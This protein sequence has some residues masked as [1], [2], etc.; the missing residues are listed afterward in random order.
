MSMLNINKEYLIFDSRDGPYDAH[1]VGVTSS[2]VF[3]ALLL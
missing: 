3:M 2:S 1:Q